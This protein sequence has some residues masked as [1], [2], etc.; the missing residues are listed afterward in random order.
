MQA[1]QEDFEA[2]G[3]RFRAGSFIIPNATAARSIRR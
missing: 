3:R 2:A 1:A